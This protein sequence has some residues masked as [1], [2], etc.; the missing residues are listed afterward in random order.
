MWSFYPLSS[1]IHN[2]FKDRGLKPVAV[3][4]VKPVACC[5]LSLTSWVLLADIILSRCVKSSVFMP[6]LCVSL[7]GL[8]CSPHYWWCRLREKPNGA[9][10]DNND[11]EW[12]NQCHSEENEVIA[13][14]NPIIIPAY[15]VA[16][17]QQTVVAK[18]TALSNIFSISDVF[19]ISYRQLVIHCIRLDLK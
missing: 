7:Q 9:I 10:A 14:D 8:P 6:L 2:I 19:S 13:V 17:G 18:V 15:H 3:K 5:G 12:D 1:W 11:S 4:P 16:L